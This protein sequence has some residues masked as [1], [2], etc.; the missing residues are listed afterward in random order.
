M[1]GVGSGWEVVGRL[2]ST[3]IEKNKTARI[4]AMSF[5]ECDPSWR[6]EWPS[7]RGAG[8]VSRPP[9]LTKRKLVVGR[10]PE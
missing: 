8:F 10:L 3:I 2:T 7:L 6:P 1:R 9:F 5:D 4:R